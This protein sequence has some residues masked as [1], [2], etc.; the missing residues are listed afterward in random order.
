MLMVRCVIRRWQLV[1][2]LHIDL[3]VDYDLFPRMCAIPSN[4]SKFASSLLDCL[5][6][7]GGWG[8]SVCVRSEEEMIRGG[9]NQREDK[10]EEEEEQ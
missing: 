8:E 9:K 4:K 1:R 5:E 3:V 2:A 6:R 7:D 10:E